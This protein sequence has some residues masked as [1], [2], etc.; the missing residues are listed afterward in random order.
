MVADHDFTTFSIVPFVHLVVNIPEEI[1]GSWCTGQVFASLKDA[2]FER[3]S[4][5]RH[6][7]ELCEIFRINDIASVPTLFLYT[8]GGPDHRLT[9]ISVQISLICLFLKLDLDYLCTARTGPYHSWRN[10]VE[11]IMSIVNLG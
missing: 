11:R 2:V 3:P 10:P 1:T 8:D 9:F 5:I 6:M 4:P 7:A